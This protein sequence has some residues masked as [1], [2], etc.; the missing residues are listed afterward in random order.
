MDITAFV[1]L[2]KE[3]RGFVDPAEITDAS[4]TLVNVL[5]ENDF[6]P[7]EIRTAFKRDPDVMDALTVFYEVQAEDEEEEWEDEED[8]YEDDY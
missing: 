6:E 5:I 7:E 4:E 2:W 8:S 1:Q 3:L